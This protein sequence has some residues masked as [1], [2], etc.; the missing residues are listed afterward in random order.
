VLHAAD[1]VI[2]V[3]VGDLAPHALGNLA[4]LALLVGRGLVDGADAQVENRRFIGNA[5]GSDARRAMTTSETR[6][7]ADV[8][9][10]QFCGV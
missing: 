9:K 3:D 1:A 4:Q 10:Q 8:L 7:F 5:P 6:V 2:L